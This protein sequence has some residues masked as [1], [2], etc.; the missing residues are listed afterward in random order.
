M[1]VGGHYI[2]PYSISLIGKSEIEAML[3]I[4]KPR[5]L[6]ELSMSY[7]PRQIHDTIDIMERSERMVL[8]TR[9]NKYEKR[10]DG[11]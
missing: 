5:L 11:A 4:S 9:H 3:P 2:A 10:E 1:M 7:A 8:N 6:R